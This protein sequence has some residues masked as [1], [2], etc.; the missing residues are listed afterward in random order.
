VHYVLKNRNFSGWAETRDRKVV[1]S[2]DNLKWAHG[3]DLG[4][5]MDWAE[6]RGMRVYVS[7]KHS[8]PARK[9]GAW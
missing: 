4:A 6:S 3:K 5:V 9:I 7:E 2:S 1:A 8:A